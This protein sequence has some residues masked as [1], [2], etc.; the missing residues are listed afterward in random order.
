MITLARVF[1]DNAVFQRNT[2]IA[3]WG[4][5]DK[6]ETIAITLND[7]EIMKADVKDGPFSLLLPPQEAITDAKLAVGD[8]VLNG[9]DIGEVWIA[10][11]QSNM[12]FLYKYVKDIK[13]DLESADD[14]HLRMYTVG[15]YSFE[16]QREA[17]YKAWNPWDR[18]I[19]Y[20]EEGTEAFAAV[21]TFFARKLRETGV[22]VGIINCSWGG[23]K[24]C[25][26]TA[27]DYMKNDRLSFVFEDYEN[28]IKPIDLDRYEKIK[29]YLWPSRFA[30]PEPGRNYNDIIVA[31]TFN[32]K[33]LMAIMGQSVADA[34]A[35]DNSG[36][37]EQTENPMAQAEKLIGGPVGIMDTMI[38]GPGSEREPGALYENMVTEM[39]GY[40][41]KGALWYQ[42][43]SDENRAKQYDLMMEALINCWRDSWKKVNPTQTK[44]PFLYVQ[45]APYGTWM[46]NSSVNYPDV[47]ESQERVK[48]FVS[49][50]Y[51]ASISDVGN[52]FDIH[53]KDKKPVGE[54]LYMLAECYVYGKNY[55]KPE[56]P[57]GRSLERIADDTVAVDFEY[58]DGLH[59]V[60]WDFSE[61]NGFS[62]EEIADVDETLVPPTLGGVNALVVK[63]DGNALRNAVVRTDGNRLYITSDELK[64]K[65]DIKIEFAKT[66]FYQVNVYNAEGLPARPFAL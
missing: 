9:I 26:W 33:N 31:N 18:W 21:A 49:D 36:K 60:E 22:P 28:E 8:A 54:R 50:V 13:E 66:G 34:N 25:A 39:A 46:Q 47:R 14:P 64:G 5:S 17:G 4:E 38:Q 58:G 32:P 23:T 11:G 41:C 44:L 1:S 55:V 27:A 51:M 42:G 6:A 48:T 62:V 30:K 10:G 7:T 15:Q 40:S 43:C 59:I 56:A 29:T 45:L 35:A 12:E 3:I 19:K 57:I 37:N 61:Y 53:P 52:V 16:G 24:A 65:S 63:A 2:K 20:G